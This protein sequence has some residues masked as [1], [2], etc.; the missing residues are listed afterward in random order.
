[1]NNKPESLISRFI[2]A[3]FGLLLAALALNWA[4]SIIEAL[5]PTLIIMA[6]V[7]GVGVGLAMWARARWGGW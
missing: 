2:A 7:I 1:M 6:A 5:L 4:V 3:A